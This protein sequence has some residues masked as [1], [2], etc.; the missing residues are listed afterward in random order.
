[1]KVKGNLL[2]G[3]KG[4]ME[5]MNNIRKI[6]CGNIIVWLVILIIKSINN[7]FTK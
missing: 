7:I 3:N 6:M 4:N 2:R 1:M 5:L